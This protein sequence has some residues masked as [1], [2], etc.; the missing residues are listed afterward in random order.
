MILRDT[1]CIHHDDLKSEKQ[2][3]NTDDDKRDIVEEPAKRSEL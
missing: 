2:D 3:N 1:L